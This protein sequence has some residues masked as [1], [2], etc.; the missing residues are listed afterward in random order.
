MKVLI[1]GAD[2]LVGR[3]LAT[4]MFTQGH[5]DTTAVCQPRP[6]FVSLAAQNNDRVLRMALRSMGL[7]L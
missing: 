2:G 7:S 3:A 4:Y 1:T 5:Q 6:E